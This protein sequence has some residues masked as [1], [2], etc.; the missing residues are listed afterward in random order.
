MYD[1]LTDNLWN[2][3]TG[4][5]AYLYKLFTPGAKNTRILT[6]V[7]T[8]TGEDI[9]NKVQNP[10]KGLTGEARE[11]A[12]AA[13]NKKLRE[14]KERDLQRKGEQKKAFEAKVKKELEAAE[15][16]DAG[17]TE[18][19]KFDRAIERL[20][21]KRQLTAQ[22]KAA[23]DKFVN[24]VQNNPKLSPQAKAKLIEDPSNDDYTYYLDDNYDA[25]E[26]DI[27][28]RYIRNDKIEDLGI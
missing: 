2:A 22:E 4:T 8:Q 15:K 5:L 1:S 17:L 27:L 12:I 18:A 25:Q 23:F 26:L 28:K 14:E 9:K 21:K 20:N 19:E 3:Y 7:P 13:F 11:K 10:G 16:E 24:W 6:L